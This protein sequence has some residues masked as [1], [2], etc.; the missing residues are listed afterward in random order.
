MCIQQK[1]PVGKTWGQEER[2]R[3]NIEVVNAG[4]KIAVKAE[5]QPFR[6]ARQ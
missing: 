3:K 1:L 4:L 2:V 6:G 5:F